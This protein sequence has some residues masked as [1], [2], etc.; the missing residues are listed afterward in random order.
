MKRA[1]KIR[2]D[3][4][5][6]RGMK[7]NHRP[8]KTKIVKKVI[9]Y[10][11]PSPFRNLSRGV[12]KCKKEIESW[13]AEN[14]RKL[15]KGRVNLKRKKTIC[16]DDSLYY[17]HFGIEDNQSLYL[18]EK[19]SSG[20]GKLGPILINKFPSLVKLAKYCSDLGLKCDFFVSGELKYQSEG[21]FDR[22]LSKCETF[23]IGGDFCKRARKKTFLTIYAHISW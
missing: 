5:Q 11:E 4:T 16:I 15:A 20:K 18:L 6:L 21:D 17:Y 22:W 2:D 7:K 12:K 14:E 9:K 19:A 3:Y 10:R 8:K 1:E 13:L 23:G